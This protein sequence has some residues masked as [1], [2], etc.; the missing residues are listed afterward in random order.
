MDLAAAVDQAEAAAL[1]QS[2]MNHQSPGGAAEQGDFVVQVRRKPGE[3]DLEAAVREDIS[4][5][6]E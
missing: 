2:Q 4:H 6:Q 5:R 1:E 3:T